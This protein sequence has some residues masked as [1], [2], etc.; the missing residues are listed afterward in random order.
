VRRFAPESSACWP[1]GLVVA[2]EECPPEADGASLRL[3]ERLEVMRTRAV[4]RAALIG[5]ELPTVYQLEMSIGPRAYPA[6]AG[7]TKTECAES[8]LRVLSRWD[9]GTSTIHKRNGSMTLFTQQILQALREQT[10]LT[11]QMLRWR[12]WRLLDPEPLTPSELAPSSPIAEQFAQQLTSDD[13][14]PL[15]RARRF[16]AHLLRGLRHASTRHAA[17]EGLL[18]LLHRSSELHQ[19]PQYALAVL[20]WSRAQ[21]ELERDALLCSIAQDLFDFVNARFARVRLVDGGNF[22]A[23]ITLGSAHINSVHLQ[24]GCLWI[25]D[26]GGSLLGHEPLRWRPHS[27]VVEV[28]PSRRSLSKDMPA[29]PRVLGTTKTDR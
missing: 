19:L 28:P 11:D 12:V 1:G 9:R 14:H 26:T 8:R 27:G 23:W 18:L 15:Q 16:V 4:V 21:H 13:Q 6:G 29:L 24:D 25:N 5:T 3:T 17:I 22:S 2:D 10:A 7:K 20:A